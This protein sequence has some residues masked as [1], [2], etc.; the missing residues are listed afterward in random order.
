MKTSCKR[1]HAT[2]LTAIAALALA[3]PAA[4]QIKFR[5]LNRE[6]IEQRLGEAPLKDAE[7][8]VLLKQWFEAS[9]CTGGRLMEQPVK[10]VPETMPNVICVLPGETDLAIV[11][12]GHFDHVNRGSG[13]VDNWSGA[14]LLPSLLESM[15]THPR[16]HTFVFIAFTAEEKGLVGSEFYVKSLTPEQRA[17]IAAMVNLD[18]LGLGP[19]EVSVDASDPGLVRAMLAVA[20][21]MELPLTGMNVR[22]AGYSDSES[23][24][25]RK[26]RS[27]A[28]HSITQNTWRILHSADDRL[29]AMRMD[30]YYNTY[31]LVAGFL[32]HLDQILRPAAKA[33]SDP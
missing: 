33:G 27:I 25:R 2:F 29:A 31:R 11:V 4:G 13:V 10:N 21:A 5:T 32:A 17:K 20:R 7:R 1:A 26:I 12:G 22:Q 28:V 24:A 14:A 6:I 9:G 8:V 3:L 15:R 30:D 16:H 19:T 18:T 23:F